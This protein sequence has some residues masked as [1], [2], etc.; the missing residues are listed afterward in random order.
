MSGGIQQRLSPMIPTHKIAILALTL[1][2]FGCA[3]VPTSGLGTAST[4]VSQG[5]G[6]GSTTGRVA[7]E[8]SATTATS[9]S[10]SQV[11]GAAIVAVLGLVAL[12][13]LADDA[14]ACTGSLC[15]NGGGEIRLGN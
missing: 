5:V 13:A 10:V 7:A 12:I 6:F 11:N 2:C 4:E 15:D 9:G 1:F 3:Q 8:D 14:Q